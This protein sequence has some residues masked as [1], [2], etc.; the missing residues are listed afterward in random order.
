[1]FSTIPTLPQR[2]GILTV[3][4]V[5]PFTGQLYPAGTPLPMT[6]FRAQGAHRAAR[7]ERA[8]RGEQQLPEGR[9][10]PERLRQVQ[11]AP[12]QQVQRRR[13]PASCASASRRTTRSSRPTSTGRRAATR[14]ASS[15][16]SRSS[17]SPARTYVDQR[18][19]RCSTRRFGVS[20]IEAGKQPPVIGG[21]SMFE[22]YGITGLPE[23]DPDADRR[24][25]AAD[26]HRLLAARP[27]GDQ[28]AVPESVQ[29]QPA[30]DADEHPRPSQ[31]E[32][33]VRVPR[34]STPTCRT[35]TRST[36]STPTAAS[37]ADPPARRPTTCTTSPTSTSA[38]ARST[39]WRASSSPRCASARTTRTCRTTSRLNNR[40][41]LNLGPALRV[42]DAVLRGREPA[43][44]LRSGDQH[45]RLAP[46]TARSP[47]A[48]SSIPTAT[49]SRRASASRTR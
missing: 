33:R 43:V 2:Q 21:P 24:A 35:P 27:P 28:S 45:H 46:A 41:T 12:R 39:N 19:R 40:L 11:R 42:R 29:R 32:D 16:C 26:D 47:T 37:S 18:R 44:E 13:C 6:D 8:W 25:D 15:T 30:R 4:V 31:R 34:R 10:E 7:A 1:M 38:R 5:H 22:L 48:R 17:S 49:T 3:P 9:A 23:N 14:T 20:R 36:G